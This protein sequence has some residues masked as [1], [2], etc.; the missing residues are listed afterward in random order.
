LSDNSYIA[1][2]RGINVGGK[3][4]KMA[5]LLSAID[6]FGYGNP[7]TYLQSG[8]LVFS[9]SKID[10]AIEARR[11]SGAIAT[12]SGLEVPVIIRSAAEWSE[13]MDANP[14]PDAVSLPK[15]LS[16][17]LLDSMPEQ[18]RLAEFN[19]R[20]FG[21]DSWRLIGSAIYVHTPDGFGKSKLAASIEKGLKVAMTARNWNTMIALDE[22]ARTS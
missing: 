19:A 8:N 9:A 5:D 20:D 2:L 10:I 17:F 14:F 16:V 18:K 6:G 15:T 3:M 4:L 12:A 11:I 7:R 13:I 1:L 21:R 22:M